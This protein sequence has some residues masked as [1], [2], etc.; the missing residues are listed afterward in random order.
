MWP[1]SRNPACAG[2]VREIEPFTVRTSRT[3]PF[4]SSVNP[5]SMVPFT[6]LSFASRRPPASVILPFTVV[7]STGAATPV[8]FTPPFT[9]ET[10]TDIEAGTVMRYFV[11]L[12]H[13]SSPRLFTF[14]PRPERRTVT[15]GSSV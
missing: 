13:W 2:S 1:S 12:L 15:P 10:C 5:A 8:T 3:D 7:S 14:H 11:S 9:A 6:V 4:G